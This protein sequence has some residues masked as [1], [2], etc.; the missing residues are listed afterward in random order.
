MQSNFRG[1]LGG[2]TLLGISTSTN[3]PG[4]GGGYV[5]K[6]Q[7]PLVF[8]GKQKIT[9]KSSILKG[10]KAPP[11]SNSNAFV[12]AV[13]SNLMDKDFFFGTSSSIASN[14]FKTN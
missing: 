3:E 10:S 6:I 9:K 8:K 11:S 7:T 12:K 14:P 2:T 4:I 1:G 13:S 5:R